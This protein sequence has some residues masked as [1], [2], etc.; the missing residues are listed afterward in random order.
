MAQAAQ[1]SSGCPISGDIQDQV[2][3]HPGQ[4]VSVH[5]RRVRTG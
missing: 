2:G 1:G 3:W 5:G 4:S